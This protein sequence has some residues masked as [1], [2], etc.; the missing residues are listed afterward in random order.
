MA[1]RG[2]HR[3]AAGSPGSA[4][5][6]AAGGASPSR[7]AP[8]APP[9]VVEAAEAAVGGNGRLTNVQGLFTRRGAYPEGGLPGEGAYTGGWRSA[10]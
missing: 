3:S 6:A 9:A 1:S 7:P 8:R 5:A 4:A 10:G 2:R